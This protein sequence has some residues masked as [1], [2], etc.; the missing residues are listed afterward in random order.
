[1][2]FKNRDFKDFCVVQIGFRRGLPST[3]AVFENRDFK[4][5]C[6]VQMGNSYIAVCGEYLAET[7]SCFINAYI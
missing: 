6:V 4:D 7:I 1:M 2:V 5:F 3:I